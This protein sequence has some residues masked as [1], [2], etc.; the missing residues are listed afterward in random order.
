MPINYLLLLSVHHIMRRQ[1]VTTITEK[2]HDSQT[3]LQF[4]HDRF[5]YLD[6]DAWREQIA[7]ARVLVNHEPASIDTRLRL[8][9]VVAFICHDLPEPPVDLSYK[10]IYEDEDLLVVNKPATLP[11]HPRG[12]YFRHTLWALLKEKSNRGY[13]SFVNRIDRETSGI[14]LLAKNKNATKKCQQQFLEQ[15][16]EK[17][18]LAVVPGLFPR[19]INCPGFLVNDWESAIRHKVR[20]VY[21]EEAKGY[22]LN[23]KRART[24]FR[25]LQRFGSFS[26][27]SATPYSGRRH[28]IRATLAAINFWLL[29][30]KLYAAD[31]ELFRR[32]TEDRLSDSDKR[33]LGMERQA[34][35]A[36]KLS[37]RHPADGRKLSFHA[38]LPAD[39]EIFLRQSQR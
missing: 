21:L 10:I 26:L 28:Q 38:P 39:M 34:L 20:F 30:D 18:Y 8:G 13:F 31:E 32:F 4:L 19:E 11:C 3:L 35:H 37:L 29:G 6:K 22:P 9:D 24:D 12:R 36:S 5:T 16:V 1:A 27:I 14:V 17:L 25:L 15:Q 33:Y 7:G 2:H 23:G